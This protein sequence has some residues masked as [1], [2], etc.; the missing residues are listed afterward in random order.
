MDDKIVRYLGSF[1]LDDDTIPG[2]IIHNKET[3]TIRLRLTKVYESNK[4]LIMASNPVPTDKI[5]TTKDAV[6]WMKSTPED[7]IIWREEHAKKV[8]LYN[9]VGFITGILNDNTPVT[10]FNCR[11]VNEKSSFNTLS[12][13]LTFSAEY[14]IWDDPN[15]VAL[16][17]VGK[18]V[19]RK[20]DKLVCVVENA[21][22]WIGA[23]RIQTESN[24][25]LEIKSTVRGKHRFSWNDAQIRFST[26]IDSNIWGGNS[27]GKYT[28][29]ENLLFEIS[30]KS[31]PLPAHEFLKIR[32]NIISMLSFALK[33][34]INIVSQYLCCND[35][36][37]VY[38][39]NGTPIE[40]L[41]PEQN[42][43]YITSNEPKRRIWSTSPEDYN[44][45]LSAFKGKEMSKILTD[46]EPVF[47]L[48]TSLFKYSDMPLEM[49]YLNMIQAVEKFHSVYHSYGGKRSKYVAQIQ[50][51]FGKHPNF[52][53][54]LKPLFLS[55]GQMGDHTD[56][57]VLLSSI[58]DLLVDKGNEDD[59]FYAF[60]GI[61]RNFPYKLTATRHYYTHYSKEKKALIFKNH[62]LYDAIK[63]MKLLL[64]YRVSQY[65]GVD[66]SEKIKEQI[67]DFLIIREHNK[68]LLPTTEEL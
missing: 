34:N 36:V 33:G 16:D 56:Y 54:L 3:G 29:T 23:S 10:L 47:T 17:D 35:D 59:L 28:L 2:E 22:G 48:Y 19:D 61:D 67:E 37:F 53:D 15:C 18:R 52:S 11:R 12:R 7:L 58:A 24:G 32:S 9:C 42:K 45:N 26:H 41:S 31:S 62:E 63:I 4:D 20:Y 46:L 21:L 40:G 55:P 51:R 39:E 38:M 49:V 65:L 43:Y 6:A 64:E 8:R 13:K 27:N 60:Y 30:T 68:Y 14:I 44:F 57:V 1:Q 66:L 25:Q 5:T 50:E